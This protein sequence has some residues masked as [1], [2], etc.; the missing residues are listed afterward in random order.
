MINLN[1]L[2]KE[3]RD[4]I[5]LK[6]QTDLTFSRFVEEDYS[7][8]WWNLLAERANPGVEH[9]MIA[10]IS[11]LQGCWSGDTLILTEY[12][13]ERIDS[14]SAGTK[15]WTGMHW[16]PAIPIKNGKKQL[17]VLEL[18]N[19]QW[20]YLT[21][22]HVLITGRGD[23]AAKDLV[24]GDVLKLGDCD[25]SDEWNSDS[26]KAA[27]LAMFLADGY[28]DM[29]KVRQKYDYKR[30]SS[31]RM[32]LKPKEFHEWIKYRLRLYRKEKDV[33]D[34]AE[35]ALRKF[36]GLNNCSSYDDISV[37]RYRT[38]VLC[39]QNKDVFDK[40]HA[41]GVPIGKKSSII[42]IPDWVLKSDAAM[43]GFLAGYLATDGSVYAGVIEI[44]SKSKLLI[45]QMHVWLQSKG[46]L[47]RSHKVK[48]KDKYRLFIREHESLQ[49]WNDH[50]P[51]LNAKK[52]V[53][54]SGNQKSV[55]KRDKQL[56]IVSFKK[57]GVRQVYDLHVKDDHSYVADGILS[58]NSGKSH[59]AIA[60]CCFMDPEFSIDNIYFNYNDLV[61]NRHRL[62]P[63]SAVLVDEQS[64]SFG[65][66]SHRVM[67]ILSN[68][69]EQLRKK[70]IHFFFCAPV[71]YDEVKSSMYI[72]E[73][74]F[75]DYEN[76]EC[77]A[78]LKTRDGLTLGH[79]R[80]PHPLKVENGTTLAPPSLIAEYQK[81]KDEHLETVLGKQDM[82][83][84]EER[85]REVTKN[86]L[87]KKAEK[88]YIR[89][90]GYIPQNT[91]IQLINK[92]FPEYHAGVVPLE[93][94]G[95][96]KLDKELSGEWEISGRAT[97]KDRGEKRGKKK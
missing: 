95:R 91:V 65:L 60:M 89:K 47:V 17:Y 96:I 21:A 23:V 36:C 34:F 4:L 86:K 42:S 69:K 68:L 72:I 11:G 74:L 77:Y 57:Y 94:A 75:I 27:L 44:S 56:Q 18:R 45:K 64:Q 81:K 88:L 2:P 29:L 6:E 50:I 85:A 90:M 15:V 31:Y 32:K 52:K 78:A 8:I 35:N 80:I 7:D 22:G 54:I 83:I 92:I 48:G 66:D 87:F 71:L 19:R 24:N 14:I 13:L 33:R 28:L 46:V 26:E 43:N 58:H 10:S 76:K 53:V 82:D 97:R 5:E 93:I 41:L 30:I 20:L 79:I 38:T 39:V 49:R 3:I 62:K 37:G 51:C 67:I 61:Y 70:S 9:S 59:A 73:T 16:K 84:F 12:G 25:W 63:N 55:A 1:E 40:L